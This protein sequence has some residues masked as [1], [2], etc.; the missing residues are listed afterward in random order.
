ML[1]FLAKQCSCSEWRS[2]QN[3]HLNKYLNTCL[4]QTV[5]KGS[6]S[7]IAKFSTG[8]PQQKFSKLMSVS[9]H[10][11][12]CWWSQNSIM[13][14]GTVG[15]SGPALA[16]MSTAWIAWTSLDIHLGFCGKKNS[17]TTLGRQNVNVNSL[18]RYIS[19]GRHNGEDHKR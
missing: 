9:S 4:A 8:N 6:H 1:Q 3:V 18:M 12:Q 14:F 13:T 7:V 5:S 17:K 16:K 19:D 15:K 10:H 2:Q 11:I